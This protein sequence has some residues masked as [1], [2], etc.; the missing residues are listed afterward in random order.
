MK[1]PAIIMLDTNIASYAMRGQ[2]PA[3]NAHLQQ[4]PLNRLC[5]SV[6]SE[7]ELRY[8][9]ALKPDMKPLNADVTA[10][11]SRVDSLPWDS[12]AAEIYGPLRAALRKAGTPLGSLDELIAAHALAVGA[13]LVTN[14]KAF[15]HV[16]GL[17]TVDWT[18]P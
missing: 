11:L 16:V 4:V 14:D 15:R 3:L 10:F 13:T 9:L 18:K 17:K 1:L 8:G 12:D 2:H 6:I 5:I 7:G